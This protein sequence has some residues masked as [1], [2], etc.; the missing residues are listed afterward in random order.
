RYRVE[1]GWRPPRP[2]GVNP[3]AGADRGS[4][5]YVGDVLRS[6]AA[7][8]SASVNARWKLA[9]RDFT[10][11][12]PAVS[13]AA[14]QRAPEAVRFIV[15]VIVL[16]TVPFAEPHLGQGPHGVAAA[17]ALGLSA[18]GWIIWM[19]SGGRYQVTV[20]GLAVMGAGGGAL[21]GLS[22]LSPAIAV[23]CVVTSAAGAR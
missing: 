5:G 23:G 4:S 8:W 11:R 17:V 20:A 10:H 15:L 2:P 22:A 7:R 16:V 3:A 6:L 13:Q 14:A 19:R 9:T 18:A 1:T 21:A 12:G